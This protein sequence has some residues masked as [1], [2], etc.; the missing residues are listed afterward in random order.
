MLDGSIWGNGLVAM[1]HKNSGMK[2]NYKYWWAGD[3][4]IFYSAKLHP[5]SFSECHL[6]RFLTADSAYTVCPA[7]C[8]LLLP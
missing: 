6:R 5:Y 1:L 8:S 4:K 7:L 3:G 2:G